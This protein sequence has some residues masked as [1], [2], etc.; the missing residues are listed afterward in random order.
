[1]RSKANRDRTGTGWVSSEFVKD[2]LTQRK[3]A[4]ARHIVQALGTSSRAKGKDFVERNFAK[5]LS[6]AQ[7]PKIYTNYE[8]VYNDP[9]VDVVY[10]GM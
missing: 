1:M 8:E 6:D 7:K 5:A 4:K 9:D 10:I 3:D 2:L